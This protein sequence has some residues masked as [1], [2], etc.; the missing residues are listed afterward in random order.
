MVLD[1]QLVG[2]AFEVLGEILLGVM[3]LVVHTRLMK[4]K[5]FDRHVIQEIKEE[6]NVGIIAITLIIAGYILKIM[7]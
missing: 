1:P 3:V 6:R 7:A 4:E 2:E 5:K